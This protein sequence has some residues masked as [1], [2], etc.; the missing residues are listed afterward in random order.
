M[1][2]YPQR[3]EVTNFEF[4]SLTGSVLLNFHA[5]KFREEIELSML[6]CHQYDAIHILRHT[7]TRYQHCHLSDKRKRFFY[8][9]FTVTYVTACSATVMCW[10]VLRHK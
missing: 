4:G 7:L 10:R 9:T 2:C 3:Q 6:S 5:P 1:K 8:F